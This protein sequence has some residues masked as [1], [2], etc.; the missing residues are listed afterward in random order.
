[1][2]FNMVSWKGVLIS[3]VKEPIRV[4]LLTA[5]RKDKV[6]SQISFVWH[7]FYLGKSHFVC[8][9]WNHRKL[10][11]KCDVPGENLSWEKPFTCT[12]VCVTAPTCIMWSSKLT[13]SQIDRVSFIKQLLILRFSMVS[14]LFRLLVSTIEPPCLSSSTSKKY[15]YFP[16]FSLSKY[17]LIH[18]AFRDLLKDCISIIL[19]PPYK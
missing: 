16:W 11:P 5:T 13:S 15:F 8:N 7:L 3:E 6:S 4:L 9:R 12:V 19:R 18:V 2:T 10:K 17:F 14:F 1:M